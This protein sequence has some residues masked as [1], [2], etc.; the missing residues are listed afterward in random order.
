MNTTFEITYKINK[1]NI[2]EL[3]IVIGK[4][5]NSWILEYEFINWAI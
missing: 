4:N 3:V 2:N 5:N 1:L